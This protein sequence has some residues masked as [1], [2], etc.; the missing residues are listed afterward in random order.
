M[1]W[2]FGDLESFSVQKQVKSS[3]K[4]VCEIKFF[5]GSH[6][7]IQILGGSQNPHK[8]LQKPIK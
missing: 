2:M 6:V 8:K 5:K 1:T 4:L 7:K 3:Q